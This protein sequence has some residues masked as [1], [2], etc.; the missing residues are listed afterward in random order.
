MTD[1]KPAQALSQTLG[2]L[3]EPTKGTIISHNNHKVSEE[4]ILRSIPFLDLSLF[5]PL[6]KSISQKIYVFDLLL[7]GYSKSLRAPAGEQDLVLRSI[8]LRGCTLR[9]TI[10]KIWPSLYLL[11]STTII[12]LTPLCLSL[13]EHRRQKGRIFVS[14]GACFACSTCSKCLVLT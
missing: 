8:N 1:V 4:F 7:K 13:L 6:L 3:R 2:T 11:R 9:S 14:C 10:S 5:L 12:D